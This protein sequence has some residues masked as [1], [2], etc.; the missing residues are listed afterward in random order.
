MKAAIDTLSG[1]P[2]KNNKKIAVLGCMNDLGKCSV[3]LHK[4]IGEYFA[5]A[6]IDYLYTIGAEAQII[7]LEAIKAGFYPNKT[8]HF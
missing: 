5:A 1:M 8:F 7:K 4:E 6:N 2:H 3:L